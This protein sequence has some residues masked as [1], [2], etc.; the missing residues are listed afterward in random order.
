MA[1]PN[2]ELPLKESTN[3][4]ITS[5][6]FS[7]SSSPL[8]I[9]LSIVCIGLIYFIYKNAK[10]SNEERPNQERKILK[11]F[12]KGD[13]TLDE[14][15]KYDGKNEDGRVLLALDNEIYDVTKGFRFYGPGG[16]YENL[17]GR[18]AT[19]ALA[20]FDVDAVRDDWDDHSDLTVNQMSTVIEWIEQFKEKYDYV[21]RL[22]RTEAEKSTPVEPVDEESDND[23]EDEPL[24]KQPHQ[25]S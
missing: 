11:P 3:N 2:S 1:N 19:R 18:D 6:I 17:G 13:L 12:P 7:I 10:S 21:G 25:S 22:V 24:Q 20:L 15:R 23:E 5:L 14:L 4:I 16:P 9:T 8:N